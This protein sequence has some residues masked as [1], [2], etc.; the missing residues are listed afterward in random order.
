MI[1]KQIYCYKW[2]MKHTYLSFLYFYYFLSFNIY[3]HSDFLYFFAF[4]SF[5]LVIVDLQFYISFRCT[6]YSI[7]A[8]YTPLKLLKCNG[9]H[10]LCC[11]VYHFCFLLYVIV[12]IFKSSTPNLSFFLSLSPLV[13]T[14]L[15]SLSVSMFLFLCIH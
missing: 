4:Y 1:S 5:F 11:T 8:D 15:F 13:S 2:W 10:S 9:Y 3:V 14:S 6:A 12:F 7:F